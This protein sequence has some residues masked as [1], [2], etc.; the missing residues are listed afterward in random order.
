MR[1]GVVFWLLVG[2]VVASLAPSPT[3]FIHFYL[4]DWLRGAALTS[5]QFWLWQT[6]D[7]YF[8]DTSWY[9]LLL[10]LYYGHILWRKNDVEAATVVGVIFSLGV[11][12]A[13]FANFI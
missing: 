4:Q 6:F 2:G 7:W 8:V 9:L 13:L 12:L 1:R 3:D 11:I 10:A 5:Y